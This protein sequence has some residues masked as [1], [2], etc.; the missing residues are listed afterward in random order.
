MAKKEREPGKGVLVARGNG[1]N[2][3]VVLKT[4]GRLWA[5]LPLLSDS[6]LQGEFLTSGP[7]FPQCNNEDLGLQGDKADNVGKALRSWCLA[8]SKLSR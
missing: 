1:R 5:W 7:Q 8:H 4:L 3:T 2:G 6:W